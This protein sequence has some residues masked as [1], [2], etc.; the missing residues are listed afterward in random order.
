MKTTLTLAALAAMGLLMQPTLAQQSEAPPSPDAQT[1]A[2]TPTPAEVDK[3]LAAMREQMA[4]MNEQ[5]A[6]IREAK[7]P[8]ERQ[9][10]LDEHWASMQ[11]AMGTMNGM[12]GLPGGMGRHMM[13]GAMGGRMMGGGH[14]MMW[15]DYRNLTPEQMKERQYMMD[16]FVPMQQMMMSHMMWHQQMMQTPKDSATPSK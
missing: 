10:L 16:R 11:S 13:G 12:M 14:M 9:R 3:Q 1:Q 5:M 8:K 7:D 4:K 2:T 6:K 15:N